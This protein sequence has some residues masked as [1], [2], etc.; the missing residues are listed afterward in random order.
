MVDDIVEVKRSAIGGA[1]R[2]PWRLLDES[3]E[4]RWRCQGGVHDDARRHVPHERLVIKPHGLNS[5]ADV[6]GIGDVVGDGAGAIAGVEEVGELLPIDQ[7]NGEGVPLGLEVD[8][9]L[10]DLVLL[11]KSGDRLGTQ[12]ITNLDNERSSAVSSNDNVILLM[13]LTEV[14]TKLAAGSEGR[15]P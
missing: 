13:N 4:H 14:A 5:H 7:V 1:R 11:E 12:E 15:T 6:I 9:D 8:L 3:R 10:G 2:E